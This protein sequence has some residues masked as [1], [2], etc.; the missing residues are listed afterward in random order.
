MDIHPLK[1]VD[2]VKRLSIVALVL[3]A[4]SFVVPAALAQ[5]TRSGSELIVDGSFVD[6]CSNWVYSGAS[7]S[8]ATSSCYSTPAARFGAIDDE[9]DQSTIAD[10][11]GSNFNLSYTY[12]MVAFNQYENGTL[13]FAIYD[14]DA[15]SGAPIDWVSSNGVD[16]CG[17]RNVS[18]GSHPEWVGHHLLVQVYSGFNWIYTHTGRIYATGISLTQTN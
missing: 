6:N 9:V 2:M 14:Q 4:T 11:T 3:S 1:G 16:V 17:S 8:T 18:L 15:N 13:V 12:H 10:Q 5:C 7:R